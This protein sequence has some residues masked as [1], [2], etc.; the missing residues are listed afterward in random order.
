MHCGMCSCRMW[1]PSDHELCATLRPLQASSHVHAL[2]TPTPTCRLLPAAAASRVAAAGQKA[3]SATSA[4]APGSASVASGRRGCPSCHSR[5]DQSA[6]A[7]RKWEGLKGDQQT[8]GGRAGQPVHSV[9]NLRTPPGPAG[10]A[11]A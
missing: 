5:T 2:Q 7:E 6:E 1:L 4:R 8:C 9:G 11:P 10:E 3:A